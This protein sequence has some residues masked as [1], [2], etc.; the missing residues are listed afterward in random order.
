[1]IVQLHRANFGSGQKLPQQRVDL[2]RR[3]FDLQLITRPQARGI[4]MILD[5]NEEN[6]RQRALQQL[7]LK[8]GN[9]TTIEYGSSLLVMVR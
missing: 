2:F 6:H 5:N 1:M 7:A 3:I 4:D 8:M 9:T